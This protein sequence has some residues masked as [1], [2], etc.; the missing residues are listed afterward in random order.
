MRVEARVR[1][2]TRAQQLIERSLDTTLPPGFTAIV[3]LL[4]SQQEDKLV[5]R[6]A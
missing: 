3:R 2:V 6:A 1:T 5:A 4:Y